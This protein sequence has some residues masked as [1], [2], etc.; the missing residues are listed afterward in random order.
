MSMFILFIKYICINIQNVLALAALNILETY[1]SYFQISCTC[2][3]DTVNVNVSYNR[4][5]M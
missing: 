5:N 2:I 1:I 4:I 3:P